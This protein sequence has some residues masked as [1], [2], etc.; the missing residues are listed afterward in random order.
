M[1][2][3][4]VYDGSLL[5][6]ITQPRFEKAIKDVTRDSGGKPTNRKQRREFK[7]KQ[8]RNATNIIL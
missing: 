7:K 4:F 5:E 1:I 2:H 6:D 3:A 8:R